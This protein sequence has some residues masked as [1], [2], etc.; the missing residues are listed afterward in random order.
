MWPMAF[1]TST[2]TCS[3]T[4]SSASW[5]GQA[6]PDELGQPGQFPEV[7]GG[8]QAVPGLVVLAAYVA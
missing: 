2:V 3:S 7:V 1:A 5:V 6:W 8:A 4:S